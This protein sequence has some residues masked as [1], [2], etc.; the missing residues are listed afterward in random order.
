VTFLFTDIEGS[1]RLLQRVG[2][3]YRDLLATHDRILRDAIAAGGGVAVQTEGDSF[4]AAFR[5]RPGRYVRRSRPSVSSLAIRGPA[6]PWFASGWVFTPARVSLGGEN[7]VGLDVHRAARM[8]Q[9]GT[10][11]GCATAPARPSGLATRI[12]PVKQVGP[13]HPRD[14]YLDPYRSCSCVSCVSSL[15][16]VDVAETHETVHLESGMRYQSP[17]WPDLSSDRGPSFASVGGGSPGE[18]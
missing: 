15:Y 16:S 2:D 11:D 12:Q 17:N 9:P 4:F 14:P 6:P 10:A 7:Y 5:E 3:A 8:P 13:A 18:R 1:T